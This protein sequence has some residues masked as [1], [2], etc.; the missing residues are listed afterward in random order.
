MGFTPDGTQLVVNAPFAQAVHIWDLRAIRQR[1]KGMGLDW[2]WTEFPPAG[3][4]EGSGA[5]PTIEVICGASHYNRGVELAEKGFLDEAIAEFRRAIAIDPNHAAAHDHLGIALFDQKKVDEAVACYRKSIELDA[6]RATAHNNLG[7]ALRT[8]GRLDEA[9]A[10]Y[11]RAIELAP[12]YVKAHRNLGFALQAQGK[13]GEAIAC[14]K[15]VVEI[16]PGAV[17]NNHLAWLLVSCPEPQFRDAPQA[18]KLAKRAVELG[19]D[20]GHYWC[21]LGV[22]HYRAGDW[23]AAATALEKARM[24]NGATFLSFDAFF[25]A[26]SHWRLGNQEAARRWYDQA[27]EW[28]DKY[29]PQDEELR[30]FRAEAAELLH[31]K[32]GISDQESE[33]KRKPD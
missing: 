17:S 20:V 14:I 22:A 33:N 10:C 4:S 12:K 30:R 9:I 7:Y 24:L 8:Q 26:M 16:D 18:V 25:L 21:T 6:K 1:L 11:K 5:A 3:E 28:M 19:P 29:M 15:E 32:S 23:R 2:D 31:Q 13:L 27:I